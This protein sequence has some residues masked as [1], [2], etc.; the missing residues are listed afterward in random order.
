MMEYVQLGHTDLRVSRLCQGTAFR[1]LPRTDNQRALRVLE[2]AL[3]CG[4]NFFDTAIAY[5]WGGSEEALGRAVKG[6]RD[7]LVLCSK[8]PIHLEEGSIAFYDYTYLREQ[9]EGS[10]RRLGTDYL[11]LYLLHHVDEQTPAEEIGEAMQRLV[12][13]SIV[14]YWGVSNHCAAQ[15]RTLLETGS[16]A[17]VE[18]Y[19]NIAGVHLD[20]KGDSRTR[21]FEEEMMPLLKESEL[22]CLAFSPM[23]KG[24]LAAAEPADPALRRLVQCIDEVADQLGVPRAAICVSWVAQQAGI[25]SVLCGA[26]SPEQVRVNTLGSTLILPG[27]MLEM[28]DVAR[29]RYRRAQR[30]AGL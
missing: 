14:R 1:H 6:R 15:V 11:D 22:G 17:A 29:Q 10:L 16:V 28:L 25:T 3:D 24:L 7:T 5:G 9:L 23:D 21:R 18:E 13:A 30:R 26:E 8:V 27:D 4:I 20:A 19:Y 2:S 12:D